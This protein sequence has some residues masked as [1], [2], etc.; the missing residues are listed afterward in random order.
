MSPAAA[1]EEDEETPGHRRCIASG[2][3]EA[4]LALVRF[5]V[6]PDGALVPDV[7][8][9]LPGRGLW[10]GARRDLIEKAVEKRLF[11]KAARR[12]VAMPERLA[13]LVEN[14][15]AKRLG[16]LLGLAKRAGQAVSGFDKVAELIEAGAAGLLLIAAEAAP[17]GREKMRRL[18][19]GLPRIEL[20]TNKELSLAMGRENVVHAA[21]ARGTFVDRLTAESL[22]LAGF[23]QAPAEHACATGL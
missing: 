14:L 12:D 7:S 4:K 19:A 3:S 1:I 17:N 22:R 8:A 9:R 16:E 21:V 5:A 6:A 15:I 13:D 20:L 11:A 2:E 23:R 18:A 10:V